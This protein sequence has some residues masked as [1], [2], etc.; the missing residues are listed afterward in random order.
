MTFLAIFWEHVSTVL[1]AFKSVPY[2]H[3]YEYDDSV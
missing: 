1:K 3:A 2:T